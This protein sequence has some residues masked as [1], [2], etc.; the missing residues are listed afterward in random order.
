MKPLSD[1]E[2]HS[3]GIGVVGSGI[4]FHIGQKLSI[5]N[6]EVTI[7][8]IVRDENSYEEFK[9]IPYIIYGDVNGEIKQIKAYINQPVY[10]SLK[11]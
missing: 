3:I 10:L 7:T 11:I 4:Q 2:I 5:N 9:E 1:I 8:D 6:K